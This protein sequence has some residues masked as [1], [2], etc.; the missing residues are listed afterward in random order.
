VFGRFCAEALVTEQ[1]TIVIETKKIR[2]NTFI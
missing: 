1:R 2:Q